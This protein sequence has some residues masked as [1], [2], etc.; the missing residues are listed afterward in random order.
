MDDFSFLITEESDRSYV[1]RGHGPLA[2]CS[3]TVRFRNTVT[4]DGI[5]IG[6]VTKSSFAT[7][8]EG[9]GLIVIRLKDEVFVKDSF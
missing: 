4:E 6:T 3:M 8:P 1:L 5:H 2:S 7:F 9:S